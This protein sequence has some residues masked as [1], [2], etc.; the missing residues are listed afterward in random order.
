MVCE[1]VLPL[2]SEYF[3]EVLDSKT[4]IEV[5]QHLDQVCR[6]PERTLQPCRCSQYAEIRERCSGA[7][8]FA[9]PGS[10]SAGRYTQKQLARAATGRVGA[11]MVQNSYNRGHVVPDQGP[12]N[13]HDGDIPYLHLDRHKSNLRRSHFPGTG[14]DSFSR[15]LPAKKML[16][17]ISS[18]ILACSRLKFPK[19]PSAKVSLR[20][21]T[22]TL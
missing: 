7:G 8:L 4:S 2:L 21:M 11:S 15:L 10:A 13:C 6:L 14:T 22:F 12:G 1:K 16:F 20:L 18:Q 19:A 5:S 9:R 3:D 17:R